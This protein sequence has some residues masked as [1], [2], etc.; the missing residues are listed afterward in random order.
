MKKEG[1]RERLLE[2]A[3]ALFHRKGFYRTTLADIAQEAD[4]PLGNVYYHFRTKELLAEAVI[5]EHLADI[6][7]K[8]AGWERD[9]DPR[10]R[11][12]ALVRNSADEKYLVQ[13]G[14]PYGS[15]CQELEK[16]DNRLAEQAG[17][18][19][20]L[21]L[22]WITQQFRQLGKGEEAADLAVDL[23]AAVQGISLL[24]NGCRSRDML[25]RKIERQEAWLDTL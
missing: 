8:M 23:F 24:A 21:Y 15:L 14:C 22:D 9:P 13:Y 5:N 4:I 16:D 20:K 18:M 10:Q 1:K 7:A 11:L 3:K 17:Q 12:K 2:A 6:R 25:M 19:L